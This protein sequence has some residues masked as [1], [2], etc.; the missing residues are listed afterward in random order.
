L[1]EDTAQ[2][3]RAAAQRGDVIAAAKRLGLDPIVLV[4][5]LAAHAAGRSRAAKRI[6]KAIF[7]DADQAL[8]AMLLRTL[9]P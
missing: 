4:V 5:G 8:V 2:A 3:I 7:R 9:A 1:D 6:A